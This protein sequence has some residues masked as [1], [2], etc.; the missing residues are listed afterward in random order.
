MLGREGRATILID[1]HNSRFESAPKSELAGVRYNSKYMGE[2]VGA[3]KNLRALHS[4]KRC[5][6]GVSGMEIYNKLGMP[7][8]LAPGK[9]NIAVFSFGTFKYAML[10][11]NSN[12]MLPSLRGEIISHVKEKYNAAAEVYTT[13]T[14]A[15]NSVERTVE[16]V[17]GRQ[18]KFRRLKPL[19]DSGMENAIKDIE[20]VRVCY[21][22]INMKKFA[23]W[24]P[25]VGDI[26]TDLMKSIIPTI[27][28]LGP[29]VMVAGFLAA[30]LAISLI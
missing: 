6:V 20:E 5:M 17:L 15:V 11:F 22:R 10:H 4:A 19:I 3:I 2:Y 16:N 30:A 1:A 18:T 8:D 7:Q 12:N 9:L 28:L 27:R 14:H 13:D 25:N 21:K 29:V 26:M 23:L 24:G